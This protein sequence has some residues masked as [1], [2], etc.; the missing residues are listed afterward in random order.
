MKDTDEIRSA[1]LR[2]SELLVLGGLGDWAHALTRL[3][4]ESNEGYAMLRPNIRK[5]YGGMGSLNDIVLHKDG[6]S[7]KA[8]NDEFDS[9]RKRLYELTRE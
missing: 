4:F 9:L 5:M 1:L 3:A 2:M 6:H 7:S 8:E